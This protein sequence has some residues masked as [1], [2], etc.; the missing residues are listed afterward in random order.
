MMK[1][2]ILILGTDGMGSAVAHALHAAGWAV[3]IQDDPAPAHPRRG[4]AFADALRDREAELAGTQA[5]HAG[6]LSMFLARLEAR[7]GRAR[8]QRGAVPQRDTRT[9]RP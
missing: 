8:L 5:H 7:P 4:M 3:A 2:R 1:G 9:I 6:D